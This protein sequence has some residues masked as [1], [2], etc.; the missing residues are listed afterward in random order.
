MVVKRVGV[1]FVTGTMNSHLFVTGQID[2]KFG[3]KHQ[4]LSSIEP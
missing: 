2:M 1:F 3:Q 4:S